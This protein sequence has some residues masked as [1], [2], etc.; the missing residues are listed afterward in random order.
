M[1]VNSETNLPVV[2]LK[3]DKEGAQ[4][5]YEATKRLSSESNGRISIWMDDVAISAPGVSSAIEGGEAII[6]SS[7]LLQKK[8][9]AWQT[10]SMPVRCLLS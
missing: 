8:L 4:N 3:L 9:P 10:K 6:E 2:S 7:P 1:L 5:F